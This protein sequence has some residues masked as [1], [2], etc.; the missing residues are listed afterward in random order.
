MNFGG[1]I[2]AADRDIFQDQITPKILTDWAEKTYSDG[3]L[4]ALAV[5][6][7]FVHDTDAQKSF[8]SCVAP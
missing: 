3:I 4:L 6:G 8:R 2:A 1:S 7:R 5:I